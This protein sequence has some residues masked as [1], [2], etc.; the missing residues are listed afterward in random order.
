MPRVVQERHVFGLFAR[1]DWLRV[2]RE[3]GFDARSEPFVHSQVEPGRLE[4]F[5]ARRP[6]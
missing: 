3:A 2:L 6:R 4:V 1:E 5:V